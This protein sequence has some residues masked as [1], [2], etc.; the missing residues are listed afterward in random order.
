MKLKGEAVS[1]ILGFLAGIP[2][3]SK[4]S[5][6]SLSSLTRE[7]RFK[8][9][10]KGEVLFFQSDPSESAYIVCS[11]D[12]S[13]VLNSPDGREMAINEMRKG[14]LFGELGII[15]KKTAQRAPSRDL[16]VNC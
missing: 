14:D 10:G 15:T 7:C 5:E 8:Q 6:S 4:L 9:V 13:I 16:P 12:I 1:E 11:G 3:F 2:L